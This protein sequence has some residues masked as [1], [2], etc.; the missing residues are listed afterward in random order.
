MKMLQ[1]E[2]RKL[3]SGPLVIILL[4]VLLI[5]NTV[6]CFVLTPAAEEVDAEEAKLI[7]LAEK[8][9]QE[10]PEGVTMHYLQ[11]EAE[12]EAYMEAFQDYVIQSMQ[13]RP[14]RPGSSHQATPLHSRSRIR[15]FTSIL[16]PRK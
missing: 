9:Y 10:D 12:M 6:T 13:N 11:M 4:A 14:G 8:Y 7:E 15:P 1:Y 16:I 3:F 5:A 2:F